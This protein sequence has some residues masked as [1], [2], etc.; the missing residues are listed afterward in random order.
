MNHPPDFTLAGKLQLD[1]PNPVV[2]ISPLPG[3]VMVF[4]SDIPV[5][6]EKARAGRTTIFQNGTH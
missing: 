1:L 3:I 4:Q 5:R 2:L 6:T